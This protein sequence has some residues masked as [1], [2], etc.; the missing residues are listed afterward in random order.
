MQGVREPI[1]FGNP[2]NAFVLIRKEFPKV[3]TLK[4]LRP[5]G[6]GD[7]ELEKRLVQEEL[8]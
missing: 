5:I 4:L 7:Q 3:D 6:E 8:T 2:P 1:G